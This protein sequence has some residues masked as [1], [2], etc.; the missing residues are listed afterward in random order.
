MPQLSESNVHGYAEDPGDPAAQHCEAASTDTVILVIHLRNGRAIRTPV[1]HWKYTRSRD[2]KIIALSWETPANRDP[3]LLY[4]DV[5]EV[6]ALTEE[7][8]DTDRPDVV[9]AAGERQ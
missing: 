8:E 2:G 4:V 1:T 6:A 5:D 9:T 3:L 7:P